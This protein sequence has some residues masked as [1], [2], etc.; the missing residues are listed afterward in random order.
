[1]RNIGDVMKLDQR[2][3]ARLEELIDL[4]NKVLST[5]RS[6]YSEGE[7]SLPYDYLGNEESA[8]QWGINSLSILGRVFSK[9]S[10]HYIKFDNLFPKLN[11]P[12]TFIRAFGIL[13]GAKDDYVHGYL[14]D[15]RRMIEAEAFDDFLEQ[16]EYLLK[17]GYY[18]PAAVITGCVLED[19]LRKISMEKGIPL[20]PEA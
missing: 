8:N 11:Q 12:D 1:M 10:D 2:I 6:G 9:N 14:L 16:A 20:P 13:K 19:G 15:A 17:S 5:R 3:V 7:I 18:G 4:G